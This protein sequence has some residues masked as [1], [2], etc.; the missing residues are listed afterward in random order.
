MSEGFKTLSKELLQI[1][2]VHQAYDKYFTELSK[3]PDEVPEPP[4][5]NLPPMDKGSI[6]E[7]ISRE[8][9]GDFASNHSIAGIAQICD[10]AKA[11]YGYIKTQKTAPLWAVCRKR[12]PAPEEEEEDAD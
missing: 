8:L 1:Y 5:A 12:C 4:T 7:L 9:D 11:G 6:A 10:A 3:N 2:N